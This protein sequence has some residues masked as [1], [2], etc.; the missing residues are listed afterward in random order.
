MTHRTPRPL[1]RLPWRSAAGLRTDLETELQFYLDMRTD[2]LA[3]AGMTRDDARAQAQREFGDIEFTRRYCETLDRAAEREERRAE[4]LSELWS[5]L[6]WTLRGMRHRPGFTA[7]VAMTLALGV[8]ANTAVFSVIN[9]VLLRPSPFPEPDRL[10]AVDENNVPGGNIHSDVAAAEYLDWTGATRSLSGIAGAGQRSL[11]FAE[12]PTPEQ[13]PGRRVTANFFDV[14]GAKPALGR[15]FA[16]GEDRGVNHVVVLTDGLWRRLFGADPAI[17]GHTVVLSGDA[18]VV[19]GVLRPDFVFP[20]ATPQLFVPVDLTAAIADANRARKF[21]FM[22]AFARLRPGKTVGDATAE[23]L[24]IAHRTERDHPDESTGH[25]VTV[26]GLREAVVADV[27]PTILLLAGAAAFVLL[28]ACANVANLSLSRAL[29]RRREIAVRIALGASRQRLVRQILTESLLLAL[30]GGAIG[31][32]IASLATPPLL[33][34]YPRALP[35]GYTVHVAPLVLVCSLVL[36]TAAAIGFG[37]FPALASGREGASPALRDGARGSTLGRSTGRT[38][39]VLV[40]TQMTLAMVLLIGAGL[41]VRTLARL[42]TLD[43]G[44]VSDRVTAIGISL[45]GAK[46]ADRMSILSFWDALLDGVRRVPGVTAVAVAS[47]A[48][49]LGGSGASL[50]IQGRSLSGPPPDIRYGNASEDYLR[51]LNISLRAG[52]MFEPTDRSNPTPLVLINET[53][54][55]MFWPG[56]SA[57]GA[58]VRLGPDPSVPWAKVVGVVGDFRSESIDAPIQPLALTYFHQDIWGFS[59]TLIVR[60]DRSAKE[61]RAAVAGI[62]HDLDPALAVQN[63]VALTDVVAASL[64]PRRFALSLLGV[65]ALIAL[66]LAVVGLYGVIGYGVTA[67]RQEFG[68]RLALGATSRQVVGMVV[69]EGVRLA[70]AGLGFGVVCAFALT[71]FLGGLLFGVRP[72]DLQTFSGVA[73]LLLAAAIAAAWLPARQAAGVDPTQALRDG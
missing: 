59:M 53:A 37:L 17:V 38:R 27:E 67:R 48:P 72:L 10:V 40:V 24:T 23:L 6:K 12:G 32:G 34:L 4:W 16:S 30:V 7:L 9:S 52:R 51:A 31:A 61:V 25:L 26:R 2:D 41:L 21:H 20:G 62:V 1:F 33:T 55:R 64:A 44:F 57:V 65:F 11:T 73:L 14:L 43:L 70:V 60:A 50:V 46:Y 49:L 71:R 3:G 15:T 69:G 36:T 56:Q 5:D 54:A 63:G 35:P 8:G 19:V 18:Y 66:V 22:H 29:S 13:I 45:S 58:N 28:I 68:V 42:Q 39:R 47:S